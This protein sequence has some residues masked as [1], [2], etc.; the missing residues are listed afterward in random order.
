M[1]L[2]KQRKNIVAQVK[3]L[4]TLLKAYFI[5]NKKKI[6]YIDISTIEINRYLAALLQMLSIQGYTVF[7]PASK[8]TIKILNNSNGEFRYASWLL[9]DKLIKF[10]TPNEIITGKIS[11]PANKLSNDYF[12][13]S[14]SDSDYHVPM[15]CYPA[16]YKQYDLIKKVD[17][18][19][20]ERKRSIFM[21]GN[22]DDKYYN[23]IDDSPFFNQPSR[24]KV[25]DF[26]KE[27]EYY[28]P[29]KSVSHL[30]N[31]IL[32]EKENN[33]I[34]IDTKV[35]FRIPFSSLL[36]YLVNFDFFLALPGITIPQSHNLI[37]AMACGSIPIIH[38]EYAELMQ[39]PLEHHKNALLFSDLD[40]L[41]D[42]I[43]KTFL[44]Q[45]DLVNTIRENV[46]IYYFK[47]LSPQA[48]ESKIIDPKI[49]KIYIQAEHVSL[50]YLNISN[51]N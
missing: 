19:H 48:I 2:Y 20:S 39:P 46:V 32:A 23:R 27:K 3:Y 5:H 21:A 35:D 9:S 36:E 28:N 17:P 50:D 47:F 11:I 10:G 30:N 4:N 18:Y 33:V 42:I 12:S 45:A 8:K 43:S 15:C 34:L 41:D 44:F 29:M 13:D 51:G 49:K 24:K 1:V 38:R 37:E 25:V 26:L 16:F 31:Y 40:D 6:I 7:V 22:F 14:G